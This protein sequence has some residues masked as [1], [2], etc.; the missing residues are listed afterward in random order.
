VRR[1]PRRP[2]AEEVAEHVAEGREDVL[3][4]VEARAARP[5]AAGPQRVGPEP[6]VARALL[7]VGQHL[8][9]VGRF[10]ELLLRGL[11]AGVE[12][13]VVLLG[14]PVVRLLDVGGAGVFGDAENFIEVAHGVGKPRLW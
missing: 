11:V 12:V 8:V 2:T 14:Q 9:G 7:L 1:P 13:R 6:I 3:D 5:T 4:R 10:F